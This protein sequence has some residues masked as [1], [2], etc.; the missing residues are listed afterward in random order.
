MS[1]LNEKDEELKD[2][3]LKDEELNDDE[4][5]ID[6][7][8]DE[9]IEIA[10]REIVK[11]QSEPPVQST[12]M[13]SGKAK[14][15][16]REIQDKNEDKNEDEDDKAGFIQWEVYGN[17]FYPAKETRDKLSAGWYS[18]LYD[19]NRGI[20]FFKKQ[21]IVTEKILKLPDHKMDNI[22]SDIKNFWTKKDIYDEYG[23][24]YKRGVLLYG[25]PGC[26]KTSIIQLL[27]E[28]LVNKYKGIVVNMS[29]PDDVINFK[30]VITNFSEIEPDRKIII[31]FEDIDNLMKNSDVTTSLLNIL[32]GNMRMDNVVNIA[33]TNYPEKM[34]E[35]FFNRPSRF[36]ILHRIGL[37]NE[38]VRE[39]YIRSKLSKNDIKS[40]DLERW[41]K[42]TKDFTLDHI[43]E[44]ILLTFV[45]DT[46]FETSISQ[47]QDM[48]K[49]RGMKA[50]PLCATDKIGFGRNSKN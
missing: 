30:D 6:V 13:T 41:I 4:Y 45:L 20:Y 1:K 17:S 26:G 5:Y 19:H 21:K 28:E 32:D 16:I 35:R 33:T 8:E 47:L 18:P 34:Q 3:E 44:L 46:D 48:R 43:K 7:D 50:E 25:P 14:S 38:E 10:V 11:V 36:D 15:I 39:F 31:I 22:L 42:E 23:F 27:A 37:P 40:I 2:E 49:T 29:S 12:M 24:V 9:D